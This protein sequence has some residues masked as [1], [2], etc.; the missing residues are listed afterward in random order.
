MLGSVQCKLIVYCVP[1][2]GVRAPRHVSVSAW[3][4]T[5]TADERRYSL[6]GTMR[7][8]KYFTVI[9]NQ[10]IIVTNA[11]ATTVSHESVTGHVLTSI[12][13]PIPHTRLNPALRSRN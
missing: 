11:V 12:S 13:T 7:P 10:V 2:Y 6:S 5:G 1:V 4:R 9:I 8:C 3:E